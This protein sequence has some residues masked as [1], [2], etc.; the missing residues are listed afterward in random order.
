MKTTAT[1]IRLRIESDINAGVKI[2]GERLP[3]VRT[4]ARELNV[5]PNTVAAAYK[6]LRDR[7][8]VIGRG[9][10]GTIIA[11]LT[12]PL[13]SQ[14]TSVP[15]GVVDALRG[16]PDPALLPDLGPAFSAATAGH[17]VRYGDQLLDESF[18]AAARDIF[19][20]DGIDATNLITTSGAMDAIEKILAAN[21]LRPGDRVGV[22]DPGHVPVHQLVRAAGLELV[23]LAID[24]EGIRPDVLSAALEQNLAA[25]IVTPRAQ[26]PT[27]AALTKERARALSKV[28]AD[29]PELLLIQ[30]DHA[31]SVSGV[32]WFPISAPGPREATIRSLG[33][34]LGPDL[35]IS[36]TVGDAIT[37]D[38]VALAVSNGPGWVSH[39]LQ[40]AA[41]YLLT[42]PS[43]TELV[44]RAERSYADRR[45]RLIDALDERGVAAS[46][47]S[48]INVWILTA[49]EQNTIEVARGAGFAIRA[50]DAYRVESGP[51]VRVTISNLTDRQIDVLAEAIANGTKQSHSSPAM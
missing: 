42:D 30:D 38:R 25:L 18:A 22:E 8:A 1:S 14:L 5:S 45:A 31:G 7:G 6:Q 41:A 23:P 32:D 50:A 4:L 46:G 10:Q 26:N 47:S 37:I 34:S 20:S 43:T 33:K 12:R 27:G 44:A 36:V 9:R 19:T 11:P 39:L 16:S 49:D 17:H 15:E 21:D 35:R 51:A 28:I 48:G 13:L 24:E 29:S 40:R 2:P 3:S